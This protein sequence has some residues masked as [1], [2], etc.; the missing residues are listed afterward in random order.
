MHSL[1]KIILIKV[2]LVLQGTLNNTIPQAQMGSESIA[3]EAKGSQAIGL[4]GYCGQLFSPSPHSHFYINTNLVC[5]FYRRNKLNTA[6]SFVK[7]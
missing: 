6:F 5:R 7:K 3:C 4:T 1:I 2:A